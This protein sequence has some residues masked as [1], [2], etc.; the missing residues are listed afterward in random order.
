MAKLVYLAH[1]FVED[2]GDDASMN[3]AGRAGVALAQPKAADEAVALFVVRELETHAFRVV[4]AASE[5]EVLLQ[6]D[7]ASTVAVAMRL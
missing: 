5:T 4:F 1:G 6:A 2:G 7:V 3:M